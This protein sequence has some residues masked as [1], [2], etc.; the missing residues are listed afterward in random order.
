MADPS[1]GAAACS[2]PTERHPYYHLSLTL[3]GTDDDHLR[4]RG[5]S[6]NGAQALDFSVYLDNLLEKDRRVRR[7]GEGA[8]IVRCDWKNDENLAVDCT[9]EQGSGRKKQTIRKRVSTPGRGGYW[10]SDWPYYASIVCSET[11]GL[12][13]KREP[14]RVAL[15]FYSDRVA[16][17]RKE[18]RIVRID[19]ETGLGEEIPSQVSE[20]EY[21]HHD[22]PDMRYQ[23]TT[24]CEVIF[25]ADVPAHAS[26]VYLAFYGN[27]KAEKPEY[28]TGLVIKGKGLGL[29]LE[30]QYYRVRLARES[31][32]I[33]EIDL[34]GDSGCAFAHHLETNGALHWNPGIYAPPRPWL[35]A[36]DWNPPAQHSAVYGP[37][38]AMTRRCGPLDHYPEAQIS[39][40][41]QFFD[42]VPWMLMTSS[43]EIL[44]DIEVKAV[45]NGEIVLNRELV[46][47]FAWREPDGSCGTMRIKNGPRHPRHAKVLPFDTPW[48]CLF[49]RRKKCGL[50]TVT[51]EL[52]NFVK[53][54]GV[55]RT[56]RPYS[57]LQWGP[58]VYYARPL[59]YTFVSSGPGR[60]IPVPA[61]N[62]Y[63]EKMAFVPMVYEDDRSSFKFLDQLHKQLK[64]PLS[65]SIVEDTDQR[66][67][68]RWMAPILVEEFE[69]MEEE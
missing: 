34:K 18:L 12:A 20:A 44:K 67:P 19:P 24:L 38:C 62:L 57:Y 66:A 46:D 4:V 16:D 25:L 30:N 2:H 45:R 60:L 53:D 13:R 65:V 22:A 5:I 6:I 49:S 47:S 63:Y 27:R 8:V 50:G 51:A 36:S 21:Y 28:H 32:A 23:P 31:G 17:P 52:T 42:Q 26:R 69:E 37:I 39:I 11:A 33:D 64:N 14:V 55:S 43:I 10:D 68:K 35:H 41:Y 3:L 56:F 15:A 1:L 54:G 29:T 9:V 58:W 61:G 7:G 40:T 48:A 59:V